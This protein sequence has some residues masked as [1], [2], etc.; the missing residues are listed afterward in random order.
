MSPRIRRL[1][2]ADAEAW[3]ALRL[4]GLLVHPEAFGADH[5]EEAARPLSFFRDRLTG[6]PVWGAETGDGLAGTVGLLLRSG[7]KQRHKAT[8]WGMYVRPGHRGTGVAEALV[9]ALLDHAAGLVEVVQLAVAAGNRPACRFYE[10]L[11]FRLYGVERHALLVGG[12]Y[13]DEE[14][15][16][17]FLR[18]AGD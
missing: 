17:R 18:P 7:A 8:L 10:R 14:L 11:G 12:T 15:R 13:H 9:T 4:E 16:A 6:N 1:G 3:R 2:A 5:A